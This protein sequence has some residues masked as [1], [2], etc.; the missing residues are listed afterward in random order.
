MTNGKTVSIR[1]PWNCVFFIKTTT[2]EN[3]D[4]TPLFI[5]LF[6]T[7]VRVVL[8]T[9]GRDPGTVFTH[10]QLKVLHPHPAELILG[11]VVLRF[12]HGRTPSSLIRPYFLLF[13]SYLFGNSLNIRTQ[14]LLFSDNNSCTLVVQHGTP[15]TPSFILTIGFRTEGSLLPSGLSSLFRTDRWGCPV[16]Q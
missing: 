6:D 10:G 8:R 7:P 15:R 1:I 11:S 16:C 5:N 3:G 4:R 12:I 9:V 2:H 14:C 13:C